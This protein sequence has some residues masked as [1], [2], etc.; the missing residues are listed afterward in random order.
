MPN[1]HPCDASALAEELQRSSQNLPP[2]D[3]VRFFFRQL[4]PQRGPV[5]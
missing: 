1:F 3:A 5:D 4:R 2:S